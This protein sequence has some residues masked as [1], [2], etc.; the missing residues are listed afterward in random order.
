MLPLLQWES[1][2]IFKV[3]SK[4]ETESSFWSVYKPKLRSAAKQCSGAHLARGMSGST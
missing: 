3:R 4:S 1:R 2:L